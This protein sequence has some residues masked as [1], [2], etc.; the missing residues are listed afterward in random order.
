MTAGAD[1][2]FTFDPPG[3]IGLVAGDARVLL[4][5]HDPDV[6]VRPKDEAGALD[7]LNVPSGALAPPVVPAACGNGRA[8]DGDSTTALSAKDLAGGSSLVTR[9]LT[10]MAI[11]SWDIAQ[12]DNFVD[13]G[14]LA[15]RGDGSSS[16]E[17]I[18]Y[19]LRFAVVDLPTRTGSIALAWQDTSGTLHVQVAAQFV[20]PT[21]FTL[22][23]ATRRWASPTSVVCHYYIGDVLLAEI[24]S[25][26]GSI[27][28]S[29]LGTFT[30][31]AHRVGSTLGSFFA[32]TLDEL[33]VFD[34]EM[35]IEEIADTWQRITVFQPL[36]VQLLR[37]LHDP[38]FPIS[39]DPSSD[40]QLE[41]RQA[42]MALGY[43]AS[44]AEN[45]RRNILPQHAYGRALELWEQ[46]LR[47]TRLPTQLPDSGID[48]RRARVLARLRQ[49][50]GSS[51]PA[52][53]SLLVSLLGG[54]DVSQLQFLAGSNTFADDFTAIDPLRWD[55]GHAGGVS[56]VSGA[57]HFA[58]GAGSFPAPAGMAFLQRS[59]SDGRQ[60][61]QIVKLTFTTAQDKSEAGVFFG[62]AGHGNY[63]LFGLRKDTG[64]FN[65]FAETFAG[66]ISQGATS[67]FPL[68]GL[69][70]PIWLHLYQTE[71]DGTWGAQYSDTSPTSGFID[72]GTFAGPATVHWAGCYLRST[73]T[74]GG[75][76]VADF[77]DHLL[78]TPL[79]FT[80]FNAYALLDR[81]LGF[82]PDL[83]G[84]RQCIG[85]V[86]HAFI[87]G[88]FITS[89]ELLCDDQDNGCDCAPFGG[90]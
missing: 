85:A 28:G 15:T 46:V 77:D 38:G 62:D 76:P 27:G 71:V 16:Q 65:L 11:V 64:F 7:D 50:G 39:D 37:E 1:K 30:L 35:C 88:T 19:Q 9:D 23:T 55:F 22:L 63:V 44:L 89:P 4:R 25:A 57:A 78:Y 36:G 79:G 81:A 8:F 86:K 67:L 51:V 17:Q 6:T 42:G 45:L 53:E 72:G 33:A 20:C 48:A 52:L 74:M 21:G 47:P 5:F 84:A 26:D 75:A 3:A 2:G 24:T 14:V 54:A 82:V 59:V 10:I 34:R 70:S 68:G 32:G 87:H 60:A 66:G 12:Q 18:C 13:P 69:I 29:T 41:I 90:Y 83:P 80:P 61:H 73:G 56:A 43:A 40:V 31:G 58:P 49:R